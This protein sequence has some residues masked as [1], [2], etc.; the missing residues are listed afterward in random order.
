MA[1]DLRYGTNLLRMQQA[2]WQ[3]RTRR[4][5]RPGERHYS[6]YQIY[7]SGL[8]ATTAF[9]FPGQRQISGYSKDFVSIRQ[10]LMPQWKRNS[11]QWRYYAYVPR[12]LCKAGQRGHDVVDDGHTPRQGLPFGLADP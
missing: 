3:D 7:G 11:L 4:L 6:R 2:A 9:R 1:D 10:G 5:H 12:K 8:I